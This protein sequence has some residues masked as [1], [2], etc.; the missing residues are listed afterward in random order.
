MAHPLELSYNWRLP[1]GIATV[2]MVGFVLLLTRGQ[3][4]GWL[5]VVVVVVVLWLAFLLV[6]LRRARSYLMVDGSTLV[7]RPWRTYVR[8]DG[9]QVRSV[10][11]ILTPRGPSYR[12]GVAAPD[13]RVVRYLVPTAW[14]RGGHSEL[15]GW[16]VEH[17]PQ[18]ELDRGSQRTLELLRIRGLLR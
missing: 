6:M 17:A 10:K 8:I 14:L 4:A 3:A 1:V 11:Q 5:P 9:E 18:A 2:G 15:F 13:G 7:L 16:L 12:L